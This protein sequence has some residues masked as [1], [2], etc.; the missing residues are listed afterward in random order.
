MLLTK[1]RLV[2]LLRSL[3]SVI[4]LFYLFTLIEWHRLVILLSEVEKKIFFLAPILL[5]IGFL[6]SAIRWNHLLTG[7]N[8]SNKLKDLYTY[9][10]IGSFYSFFLPGVIGGDVVRIGFCS[11][12][13]NGSIGVITISVL[14]ERSCGVMVLFLMGSIAIL[15][16]PLNLRLSLGYPIIKLLPTVTALGLILLVTALMISRRRQDRYLIREKG[17][18]W[19]S[20]IKQVLS[21]VV[22]LP[23]STFLHL[24]VFSCLFQSID[25]LTYFVIAKALNLSISLTFFF[26]IM[27][28]V[29][30]TTVLPISIGGL[31]V[32][33]GALVYLLGKISVLSSDAV[34]LSFLVYFNRI[35][36][37]SIGG[38]IQMFRQSRAHGNASSA[39]K[40]TTVIKRSC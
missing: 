11:K 5:I 13:T 39:I 27:P 29:Y 18:E 38:I 20:K 10:L 21:L 2:F 25:I 3:V 22:H 34:A 8:I 31:G 14:L 28:V 1:K 23:S 33:E 19:A 7:L 40:E 16:L 4:L 6:F 24:V 37:S 35:F 26:A 32:R 36:I 30:I 9:Y 15:C 17:S 12:E